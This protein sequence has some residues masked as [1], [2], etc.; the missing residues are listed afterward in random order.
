MVAFGGVFASY[1]GFGAWAEGLRLQGDN[2]GT[3]PL[4]GLPFRAEALAHVVAPSFL[5]AAS[6]ILVGAWLVL[7][8]NA[9]LA[10]IW[11]P[12][13]TTGLLA[14]AHLMAAFRGLPPVSLFAGGMAV[15]SVAFWYSVPL[16]LTLVGGVASTAILTRTGAENGILVLLAFDWLTITLGRRRVRLLDEGHRI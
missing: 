2:A 7:V 5:Y 1:L 12:L 9:G 10:A 8:S 15:A 14:G 13:L 16:L 6:S 3:P 11:W 4:L